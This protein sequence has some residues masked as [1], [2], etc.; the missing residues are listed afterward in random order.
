VPTHWRSLFF[1]ALDWLFACEELEAGLEAVEV[2]GSDPVHPDLLVH[3]GPGDH[4]GGMFEAALVPGLVLVVPAFEAP[5]VEKG[6]LGF[7]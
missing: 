4:L 3:Q 5:Q 7:C 1:E 2:V 6:R